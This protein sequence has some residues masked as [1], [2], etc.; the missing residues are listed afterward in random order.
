MKMTPEVMAVLKS[1]VYVYTD[2]RNGRPFYIGK[3]QG[4]RLFAHLDD[5]SETEKTAR[6]SAIR[7]SGQEPRIDILR[8]GL[9][10]TEASLVE[11]SA[12]DLV[13]LS[14]LTNRIAGHH[15]KSFGIIGAREVIAMLSAKPVH[16][17]HKAILL[18]INKLY[19]SN[20]TAEELYEATRGFWRVK[21]FRRE[22]AEYGMAVYQGIV[23]EVYR[24]LKWHPAGT[25]Q[26]QTRD[27]KSFKSSGRFEFDGIV[28]TDIRSEYIGNSVGMGGQNPIRYKNI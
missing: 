12:I 17:R 24:I 13:G 21:R 9:T 16:V 19:R 10:V 25:L 18:T 20:M 15:D 14:Q 2:P 1:Y 7:K 23:R 5:T 22:Q 28:A 3:G 27:S 4:T 6:I 8:Y 11:A 26:Y